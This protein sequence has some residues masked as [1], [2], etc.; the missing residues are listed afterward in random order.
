ME[1]SIEITTAKSHDNVQGQKVQIVHLI[2]YCNVNFNMVQCKLSQKINSLSSNKN[3][4]H[5]NLF[6][7]YLEQRVNLKSLVITSLLGTEWN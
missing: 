3:F 1:S 2:I 7:Q 4:F 5:D 6:I